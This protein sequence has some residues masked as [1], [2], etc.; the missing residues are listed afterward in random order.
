VDLTKEPVWG[1]DSGST[2][3]EKLI[4]MCKEAKR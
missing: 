2:V 1:S 3:S 4:S